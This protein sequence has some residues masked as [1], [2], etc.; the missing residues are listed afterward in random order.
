M[1]QN[2]FFD[3]G[4]VLMDLDVNRTLQAMAKLM[5]PDPL[6]KKA[7]DSFEA[8]DLFGVGENR[9]MADYQDGTIGTEQFLDALMPMCRPQVTREQVIEAWDAMLLGIPE[10]RLEALRELRQRGNK[11]F[12]LSNINEEHLRWTHEHFNQIG[13]RIGEEVC[14]AFFSNEMG[15]SKPDD[16]IYREVIRRTGVVPSESLYIDDMQVNVDA[17]ARHGLQTLCAKGDEWLAFIK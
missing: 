10:R 17:G 2:Y 6:G 15:M 8:N 1:I 9:L 13:L 16:R 3:L 4:G 14:E 7:T 5:A 12:I 11:V